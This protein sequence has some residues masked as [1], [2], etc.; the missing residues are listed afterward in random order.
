[1]WLEDHMITPIQ[2]IPRYILLLSD[3]MKHTH[4]THPDHQLLAQCVV[5]MKA[6]AR[7][8]NESK[9]RSEEVRC[10]ACACIV[11]VA[12]HSLR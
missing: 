6:I 10:P 1:M 4:E 12:R 9:K 2:R 7:H 3:L 5:S 11:A 8:I